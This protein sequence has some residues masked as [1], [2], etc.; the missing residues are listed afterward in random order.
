MVGRIRSC[1]ECDGGLVLQSGRTLAE[2]RERAGELIASWAKALPGREEVVRRYDRSP[3]LVRDSR[4]NF[5]SGRPDALAPAAFDLLLQS[6]VDA[7]G[8]APLAPGV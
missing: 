6:I 7:G 3:P 1:V 8:G 5:S 4:V 2:N